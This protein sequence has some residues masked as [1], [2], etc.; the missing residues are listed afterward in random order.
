MI[1]IKNLKYSYKT[2][3]KEEGFL[4]NIKD[5]FYRK[6]EYVEAIDIENLNINKGEIVGLL[7]PN[8]A[9]KTTLIKLLTGVL[10]S[11]NGNILCNN[12]VPYKKEKEFLKEIGVV[13]GQKSQLIWDLPKIKNK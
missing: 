7:G 9:G 1:E 11:E 8:G 2:Y 6:Y 3:E 5:F 12:Y 10:S 13:L 4:G